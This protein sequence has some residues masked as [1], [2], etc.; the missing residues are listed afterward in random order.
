VSPV[1]FASRASASNDV[2]ALPSKPLAA[3]PAE[4]SLALPLFAELWLPVELWPVEL[5]S[6]ARPLPEDAVLPDVLLAPVLTPLTSASLEGTFRPASPELQALANEAAHPINAMRERR[7]AS[8]LQASI[9]LPM[10]T[11]S[12]NDRK[13]EASRAKGA[14]NRARYGSRQSRWR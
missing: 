8:N 5:A 12:S 10:A 3:S 1:E 2:A 9:L 11:I 6:A 4:A 13:F 14:T 7:A